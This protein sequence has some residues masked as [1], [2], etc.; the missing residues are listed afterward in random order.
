MEN[1]IRKRR[2][3]RMKLVH[4]LLAAIGIIACSFAYAQ[5]AETDVK[6]SWDK[7]VIYFPNTS[8]PTELNK[9]KLDKAYPVAIYMH[10]CAGIGDL[11]T[12][13]HGWA[14]LIAQQGLLVIMPDS[15]ARNDRKPSCDPKTRNAGLFPLVHRMRLEEINYATD[16]VKK[17]PWFD[18]KNLF[19]MGF[20]EGAIAAVRTKLDGFRGVIATA[21]TC[22][23]TKFPVFD[24]IFL[25]KETPLLTINYSDDPWYTTENVR[26][27][28]ESKFTGRLNAQNLTIRGSGHG[29]YP[30]EKARQAVVNFIKQHLQSQ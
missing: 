1:N 3:T 21:W 20:S 14:K 8:K 19:L 15:L 6:S 24:G 26:G 5:G 18:G 22:T 11:S 7:A 13:N 12:D 27:S 10:G 23:N 25:P 28:C 9:V 16:E 29:T 17:Q 2:V 30:D 4:P